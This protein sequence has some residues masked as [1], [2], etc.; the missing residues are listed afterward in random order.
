[1]KYVVEGFGDIGDIHYYKG[2]KYLPTK[3]FVTLEDA[4]VWLKAWAMSK[5][6]ADG[7]PFDGYN[8]LDCEDDRVVVWEVMDSGHKKVVWH[9]SGWHWNA[10]EFGLPQGKFPGDSKSVYE[11]NMEDY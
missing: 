8:V 9:F 11:I 3:E 5:N 1:M 10:D 2:Y 6:E 4:L 7:E